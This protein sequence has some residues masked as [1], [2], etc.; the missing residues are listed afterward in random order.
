M[1]HGITGPHTEPFFPLYH[2]P[3]IH[4]ETFTSAINAGTSTRGPI[5]VAKATGEAIPKTAT[6]TAI[7]SSKLLEAAVNDIDVDFG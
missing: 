3:L 4:S 5:T 2:F 7:A 1:G 6:A